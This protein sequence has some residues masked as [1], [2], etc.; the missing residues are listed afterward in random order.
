MRGSERS[1]EATAGLEGERDLKRLQP[2]WKV[3]GVARSREMQAPLEAG[4]A[5][6]P[7]SS[8]S[9]KGTEAARL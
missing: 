5:R 4:K 6:R 1:E 2:A 8:R 9:W 7:L 3:Q